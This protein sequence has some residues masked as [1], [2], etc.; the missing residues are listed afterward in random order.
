MN[1]GLLAVLAAAAVLFFTGLGRATLFDQ[2]EAKY[3]QVAREIL[4]TGDPITLHVNGRRWF[5][6][7]PLY[8]WLV[9]ATGSVV[10]FSEFT[11]R[12]WSA[13]FGL[14]GAYATYL[15]GTRLFGP[16]AAL[17]GV[18]VLVSTFQYFAQSRLAVFDGVLLAFMLLAFHALLR[19]RD[20]E[21][22]HV[23]TAG[24]WAGLG[25]LT[26]GPIALLLPAL[27][28]AAF[29]A[30]RRE[31]PPIPRRTLVAAAA[32]YAALALP[33][34][35]VETVRHGLPFLRTVIGYYTVNRFLGVVEGQSGPW[36][37]YAPVLVLGAFPW[38]AFAFAAVAYHL[39]RRRADGSLLV[40][41]W[42]AVTL[43]FYTAAGTK[44][45][46]YILPV[47]PALA[48]G[49][50]A[51]WDAAIAGDRPARRLLGW[52]L[53]GTVIALGL[54]AAELVVFS[55]M[56]YPGYLAALQQHLVAVG[57]VLLG[58]LLLA[59]LAYAA[60]RPRLGFIVLAGSTWVLAA[61][62]VF[63]T[64]PLVDARRSIRPVAA[65]V[66]AGLTP[67]VPLVGFRI[68]DQQT[69]LFYTDHPVHWLDEIPGI[70][71]VACRS[72]RMIVVGR[73]DELREVQ[74]VLTRL[75]TMTTVITADDLQ[76]IELRRGR[77]CQSLPAPQ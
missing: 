42:V 5:V 15:V 10:G 1:R 7:P 69:L 40:L 48:L 39:R 11:A 64:L 68:S 18:A 43:A 25:T 3:T 67:G 60:G 45:P 32:V 47:Y 59:V 76:A 75:G 20:G 35:V 23:V 30:L 12:L 27:V 74:P 66:R 21:T 13:V 19:A 50:G 65:A 38:T 36:W 6:H 72:S 2:D 57:A 63:Q 24:L 37:Y 53:G 56:K 77:A 55:R 49:I 8:F 17:L 16:R 51:L 14:V 44:L 62:L 58:W 33:W 54:F 28:A 29:L 9:A 41:L 34:Y 73:P 22:G 71:T 4:R 52:S 31:R 46:N 61:F 26:K 70:V